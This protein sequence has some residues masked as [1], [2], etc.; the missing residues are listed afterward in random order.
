MPTAAMSPR[1]RSDKSPETL[2]PPS[3]LIRGR[4]IDACRE[5]RFLRRLLA[6]A[7]EAEKDQITTSP[8]PAT[9]NAEGARHAC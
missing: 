4:L 3:D 7:R 8:A 5:V 6:F 2:L 1:R 9:P